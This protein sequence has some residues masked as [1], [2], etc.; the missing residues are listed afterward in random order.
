[1][2]RKN[3]NKQVTKASEWASQDKTLASFINDYRIYPNLT[4]KLDAGGWNFSQELVNEIVLWKISRYVEIPANVFE[5]LNRL[6]SLQAG[7]HK[8]AKTVLSSLLGCDG[9]RLPMA[10]TILRFANPEVFQIY[11]RHICR[12]MWGTCQKVAPKNPEKAVQKYWNFLED[13]AAQCEQ[14][15]IPFREAD[16]ILFEFDKAVNPPLSESEV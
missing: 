12:A 9:V 7:E 11:D 3:T 4:Q 16:R 15:G 14:L 1:M 13:L 6:R 2:P 5:S 8:K 10:S